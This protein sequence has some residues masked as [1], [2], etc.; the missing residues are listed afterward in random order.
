MKHVIVPIFIER[1]K[2]LIKTPSDLESIKR[3]NPSI[4]A[5]I[6]ATGDAKR[7]LSSY[8]IDHSGLPAHTTKPIDIL[9]AE[10]DH[11][12]LNGLAYTFNSLP[13]QLIGYHRQKTIMDGQ[14]AQ[15]VQI[16]KNSEFSF[17]T[18]TNIKN[19]RIMPGV[20]LKLNNIVMDAVTI[21]VSRDARLSLDGVEIGGCELYG[22]IIEKGGTIEQYKDVTFYDLPHNMFVEEARQEN[23]GSVID[24]KNSTDILT[25]LESS[26]CPRLYLYYDFSPQHSIV[27]FKQDVSF[28]NGT[29]DGLCFNPKEVHLK[30]SFLLEGEFVTN[31]NIS[32]VGDQGS[33]FSFGTIE[34]HVRLD[35]CKGT[36]VEKTSASKNNKLYVEDSILFFKECGFEEAE[37]VIGSSGSQLAFIKSNFSNSREVVKFLP[38]IHSTDEAIKIS[39]PFSATLTLEDCEIKGSK[40]LFLNPDIVELVLNRVTVND[41]R[42]LF[43]VSNCV[44]KTNEI[45]ATRAS[46]VLCMD[47][48]DGVMTLSE[49]SLG[50]TP[51]IL[52]GGSTLKLAR[53]QFSKHTASSIFVQ[54]STL[55]V[56]ASQ[57]SDSDNGIDLD[58]G[59][60]RLYHYELDFHNIAHSNIVR[61]HGSVVV[62]LKEEE[63]KGG[64]AWQ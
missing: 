38:P 26:I 43:M 42:D 10:N 48:C 1:V 18:F 37:S 21:I 30:K 4:Y 15:E 36:T 12:A 11:D 33:V 16:G 24:F 28:V 31:S 25:F 41:C 40:N 57:I 56:T 34:G 63:M 49:F 61:G 62:D 64:R 60:A 27:E 20:H 45:K 44:V 51:I 6:C 23:L 59:N 2:V 14:T 58:K 55:E 54:N 53:S 3:D 46:G 9:D 47:H 39:E 8:S 22:I 52:E 13:D 19:V 32:I 35:D 50:E 17:L 5:S 29:Q 7:L